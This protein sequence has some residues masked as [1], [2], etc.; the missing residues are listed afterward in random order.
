M[1]Q[2]AMKLIDCKRCG[3]KCKIEALPQSKAR[4]LKRAAS[5]GLCVNCA[6]HDWLRNTY[7]VNMLLAESGPKALQ[8]EH[9]R[10][11]FADIMKIAGADAKFDEINWDMIIANWNLPFVRKVKAR[12]EN[13]CSQKQLDDITSGKRLA[14]GP[15]QRPKPDPLGGKTTITSFEEVNLLELGLGGRLRDCLR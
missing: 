6:V 9:I 2:P 11:Q 15:Q 1:T 5:A 13:P 12:A 8:F 3:A 7:P 4:M 10:R 14:F